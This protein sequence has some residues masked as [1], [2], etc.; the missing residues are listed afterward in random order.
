ML[1]LATFFTQN[2]MP[3]LTFV[4][5]FMIPIAATVV[6]ISRQIVGIKGFGISTPLLVGFA[7]SIIG[8]QAGVI[9]FV[10]ALA[11]GFVTKLLLQK[12]RLL[13]L[14][15]MALLLSVVAITIFVLAPLLPYAENVD[16][17][18]AV[19]ALIILI[20][21]IEQFTSFLIERG[22]RET[23]TVATEILAVSVVIFFVFNWGWLQDTIAAYPLLIVSLV[24]VINLALGKWTGLRLSEYI[25]FKDLM[26]K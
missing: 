2:G 4:W 24:I 20:F 17:S 14:P 7:F 12:I 3:E 26:F 9:I 25:R 1:D 23:L 18:Q 6:V 16:I 19:F 8:L 10:V 11:V 13:Y 5:L 15:R 21:P 22:P